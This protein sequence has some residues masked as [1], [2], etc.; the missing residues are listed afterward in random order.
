MHVDRSKSAGGRPVPGSSRSGRHRAP[1]TP[2]DLAP[3]VAELADL[4]PEHAPEAIGT[5]PEIGRPELGWRG[6]DRIKNIPGNPR[7]RPTAGE[8]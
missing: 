4:E 3:R 8:P 6:E 7:R 2:Y 5:V 1:T